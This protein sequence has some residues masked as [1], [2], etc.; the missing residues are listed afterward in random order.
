VLRCGAVPRSSARCRMAPQRNGVDEP[1]IYQSCCLDRS[2]LRS[3]TVLF[4]S[5]PRSEVGHNMNVLSPFI[6]VL[7]HSDRRL[8]WQSIF[9]HFSELHL[10]G[11]QIWWQ[12]YLYVLFAIWIEATTNSCKR[13]F[14][15]CV[16]KPSTSQF[17]YRCSW[18]AVWSYVYNVLCGMQAFVFLCCWWSVIHHQQ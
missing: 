15:R 5:R 8:G 12:I 17:T 3:T 10:Y 4:S 13:I 18:H 1:L 16:R 6:S 14:L 7:C 2:I 9:R 11:L